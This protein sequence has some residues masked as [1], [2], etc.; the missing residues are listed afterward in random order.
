M[1]QNQSWIA[2]IFFCGS[3]AVIT[4]LALAVI[5]VSATVIYTVAQPSVAAASD[6]TVPAQSFSGMITDE[7]CGAK[8][9]LHD[10]GSAECTRICVARGSRY[11][12]VDGDKSY[13]LQGDIVK[14]NHAAGERVTVIGSLR[15]HTIEFTSI[16]DR[17]IE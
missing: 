15:D 8:H 9:K 12:L 4:A 6:E 14:L 10:K 5:V 3:T 16:D 2:L 13:G 7:H 17:S 11:V 1:K